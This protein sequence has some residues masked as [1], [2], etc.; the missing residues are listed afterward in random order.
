MRRRPPPFRAAAVAVLS[1]ALPAAGCRREA[2]HVFDESKP[3]DAEFSGAAAFEHTRKIVEMGPRPAGSENLEKSRQ[4]IEET[5]TA[6]GWTTARQSLKQKT[7]E[8]EMEFV[9][10]R[11]RFPANGETGDALWQK[12]ARVLLCSHYETKKFA[13]FAFAGANDPGSSL[14]VLLHFAEI[15]GKR[16]DFARRV[17]LVFFDGE[18]SIGQYITLKDGLYG[19]HH[20]AAELKI[21]SGGKAD[22][23]P[24]WGVLLDLVGDKDLNVRLPADSPEPLADRLLSAARD[25][26]H[27]KYFGIS[28]SSI[29]DD[30]V[31]L[32]KIGVPTLDVIDFDYK[33]WHSSTDT[34]DKLSPESLEIVGR[35]TTRLIEK[36]L[37][38]D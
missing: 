15:A 31:P 25:L 33:Y 3:L 11:A 13:G 5:L 35:V 12:P 24:R 7:P 8:G 9:N 16:P 37:L 18:E 22:R 21:Q 23:L 2:A 29:V 4:L 32:N 38:A 36:Y 20:Y 30:H 26:G 6:A 14:G 34:L 1:L 19:S 27:E 17:E 28:R 10:L